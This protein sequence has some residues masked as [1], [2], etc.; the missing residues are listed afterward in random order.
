MKM[1][2]IV[3]T[4]FCCW[5]PVGVLSILVQAGAVEVDPAA[6]AWIATFVLPINSA[7][8]PF[9]Y[10][11]ASIISDKVTLS[12]KQSSQRITEE[13]VMQMKQQQQTQDN[14]Q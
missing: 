5:V 8:N 4:D 14:S 11:L 6:Y 10:T 3:F 2:L 9:L 7:I 1:S 13:E 12:R